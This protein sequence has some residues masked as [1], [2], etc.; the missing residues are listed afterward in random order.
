MHVFLV[1]L[2]Y[3]MCG[4]VIY[5]W[6]SFCLCW[7]PMQSSEL[8]SCP[9][10]VPLVFNVQCDSS[11]KVSLIGPS[12][13]PEHFPGDFCSH[14]WI[15]G[16]CADV[17]E[18]K[19]WTPLWLKLSGHVAVECLGNCCWLNEEVLEFCCVNGK[20]ILIYFRIFNRK[21]QNWHARDIE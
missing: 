15:N 2:Y 13:K 14:S 21:R 3:L 18:S 16:H 6:N 1:A 7:R 12:E 20:L 8:K 19:I 11:Y 5:M 9:T 10:S 4:T 17:L